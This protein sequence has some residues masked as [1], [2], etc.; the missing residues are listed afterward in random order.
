[1]TDQPWTEEDELAI[2]TYFDDKTNAYVSQSNAKEIL[3]LLHSRG[4]L[5]TPLFVIDK[6]GVHECSVTL[7]DLKERYP[8][9]M[10]EFEK[11]VIISLIDHTKAM[12]SQ[13]LAEC[14]PDLVTQIQVE[15]RERTIEGI[16]L[17]YDSEAVKSLDIAKDAGMKTNSGQYW[18]NVS[19][20]ERR[21]A[22]DVRILKSKP[23]TEEK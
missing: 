19:D 11:Q 3:S 10:A 4:L 16:A 1:M 7:S 6:D 5:R 20:R 21:I 18:L 13:R 8:E 14:F 12:T 15:E 9:L 17:H 2:K 23:V 22:A